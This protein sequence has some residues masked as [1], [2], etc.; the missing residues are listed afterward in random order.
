MDIAPRSSYPSTKRILVTGGAGFVGS[1]L[2]E[3]LLGLGHEVLCIDN[4]FTGRRSNVAHLLR[5]PRFE[6]LGE[7]SHRQQ[8]GNGVGAVRAA[9][10]G[11]VLAV[12]HR[13]RA[14]ALDDVAEDQ[15][16]AIQDWTAA[17]ET[18]PPADTQ[19][20][21]REHDLLALSGRQRYEAFCRQFPALSGRVPL[22]HL[23]TYLGLTDVSLSRLRRGMRDDANGTGPA[24]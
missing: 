8:A 12:L 9:R 2:C 16:T 6:R 3:R 7:L 13:A 1:H 24:L 5:E 4:F 15:R 21:Q 11:K 19:A 20:G 14:H 18:W 22:L 10:A 17:L 23:A